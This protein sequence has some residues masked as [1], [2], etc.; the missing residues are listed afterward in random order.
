MPNEID[1][2]IAGY[3][4][5]YDYTQYS[6][7][8]HVN[9][10]PEDSFKR[11]I[12]DTFKTITDTLRATY[13]PYGSTMVLSSQSE[14][15]T[16]KD[17]YNVFQS[18]GFG[19]SY[20]RMVYLAISKIIERVNRNVGDGTTSCVLLAEKIF[21]NINKII[22]T[23][24]EKRKV[25]QILTDIELHLQI[26]DTMN[27]SDSSMVKPLSM[28]SFS[29]I[30]NLASNYD[31]A[32][33]EA[34]VDAF[35][36][37]ADENGVITSINNV[38]PEP[39]ITYDADST[40]TYEI[41]ELPG[42]YRIKINMGFEQTLNFSNPKNVKVIIYDHAFAS[43]DWSKFLL[44]FDKE[45]ELGD[46][47]IIA[48]AFTRGFMDNDFITYNKDKE[49]RKKLNRPIP[50]DVYF[51]EIKGNFVQNEIK[52][53][54]AVIGATVR[55]VHAPEVDFKNDLTEIKMSIYNG[56]CLAV[57]DVNPPVD[58]IELLTKEMKTDSNK[59]IVKH[60][61]FRD[62][63]NALSMKTQ[64]SVI[65]VHSGTTLESKMITDKI[66]DCTA[67]INSAM[68]SGVVP[69]MLSYAHHRMRKYFNDSN[70][71]DV[72]TTNII[73]EIMSAIEGLFDD[74]WHSKYL[75][76][77][78][79]DRR[80]RIKKAMYNDRCNESFNIITE[81]FMDASCL[82]TS[83]QYDLEVVVAALSIVK[84]LLTSRA[85]IFDAHLLKPIDD[86]GRYVQRY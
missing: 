77:T 17:G 85:L 28:E 5:Q 74:I 11:L 57:Y 73:C 69:N 83:A 52:D 33:T 66:D 55:G 27:P 64:D 70:E 30:I 51:A 32:L 13:G 42:D 48:R 29:K 9:V 40:T 56:N 72:L 6:N 3:E 75:D 37:I 53:F 24:D 22:D 31:D 2:Q 20:K 21:N 65:I 12:S 50:G 79:I 82:P 19:H 59:S 76:N 84:Y 35:C 15:T 80:D 8:N 62:R 47:L 78:D 25:L 54:A 38:I 10:I 67:I 1:L 43:T 86:D 41:V 26:V 16:T 23:P 58:Y 7:D 81:E 36:P 18:M 68:N 34:L 61:D 49:L 44:N 63:I 14:T 46:V 4:K 71:I 39:V 60:N 45:T